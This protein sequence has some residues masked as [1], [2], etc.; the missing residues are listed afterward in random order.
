MCEYRH[1]FCAFEWN[2]QPLGFS[3]TDKTGL[4]ITPAHNHAACT[5]PLVMCSS[6]QA[7]HKIQF[8][9]NCKPDVFSW[10]KLK[11]NCLH[12]AQNAFLCRRKPQLDKLIKPSGRYNLFG[13]LSVNF[14]PWQHPFQKYWTI[15]CLWNIW[16]F[17]L[18]HKSLTKNICTSS[19]NP[20]PHSFLTL[21]WLDSLGGF[22]VFFPNA[23][24]PVF[25]GH[26]RI[27]N[28]LDICSL[29]A[30]RN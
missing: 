2:V 6:N 5:T 25:L 9:Y 12:E 13:H 28:G 18:F 22:R 3:N 7:L 20:Q 24:L 10:N 26:P 29:W 15:Y 19:I 11:K 23:F 8:C 21:S 27:I 16:T 30:I 14:L 17:Y 1:N 4:K